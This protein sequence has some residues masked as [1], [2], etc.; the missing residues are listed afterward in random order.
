MNKYHNKKIINE[1]GEFDSLKEY[2]YFLLFK[3]EEELGIIKNL[4][5]Q[6]KYVLLEKD[7]V[8][9]KAIREITQFRSRSA[10]F[11]NNVKKQAETYGNMSPQELKNFMLNLRD[12]IESN[13]GLCGIIMGYD[14]IMG[15]SNQ[16]DILNPGC[17]DVVE[18]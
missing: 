16:F 1:Y 8:E 4:R 15:S 10:E 17:V 3:Q 12:D 6:V 13:P 18:V 9:D 5:R 2:K 14:A 7:R 11:L